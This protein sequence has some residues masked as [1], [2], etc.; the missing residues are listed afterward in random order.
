MRQKA[1]IHMNRE[2]RCTKR[3][4]RLIQRNEELRN[5]LETCQNN[6][7]TGKAALLGEIDRLNVKLRDRESRDSGGEHDAIKDNGVYVPSGYDAV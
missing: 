6:A 1:T 4:Q 3:I 2:L 5:L 7:G